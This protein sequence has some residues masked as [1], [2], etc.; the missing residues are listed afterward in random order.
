MAHSNP[1][2]SQSPAFSNNGNDLNKWRQ[3]QNAGLSLAKADMTAEQLQE[4]YSKP[5]ASPDQTDR[6][7]YEDT[8]AK[9]FGAFVVL[10]AGA[11]VG[12]WV[13]QLMLVGAIVGFVLAMVNIF[14][15]RPSAAL[16]LA[17][18]GFEGIFVGGISAIFESR[19][20]GIVIQAVL[21]TLGV[22]AVTLALFA[23]G[24]VRASK[25][26]TQ[27]FLV[28]IVGYAVFSL[29][30]FVLQLTG[31]TSGQF[32]LRSIEFLGIPL[33]FWIGIVVVLLAA[34]S[35]VLDFTQIKV[36]VDN[37]AP[38]IF[39]WQAAFGLVVTIVWLYTE[40]LR[41]LAILRGNN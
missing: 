17:Y 32:G 41:M 23:S 38:R 6:M 16:V 36:G 15:K 24:K 22:F 19:W 10:L 3:E 9:T 39:G 1:G 13:P 29:I 12:W 33:G 25:R 7:T 11:A 34:Y 14:K 4:L 18:A 35:L 5:S 21:G 8:I 37:G 30:N 27:I 26:A 40:I 2:F 28:A 20:D 31:V